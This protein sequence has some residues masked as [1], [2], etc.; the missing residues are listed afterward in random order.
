MNKDFSKINQNID[1][2]KAAK[3]FFDMMKPY[4]F[5]DEVINEFFGSLPITL[6]E[7]PAV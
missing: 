4:Q 6:N 7:P 5:Y 1:V 3:D 2:K